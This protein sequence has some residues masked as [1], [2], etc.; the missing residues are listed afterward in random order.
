MTN[1]ADPT[2]VHSLRAWWG[3]ISYLLSRL[4]C[5]GG[6]AILI[7]WPSAATAD[8]RLPNV[9]SS[10]MVVQRDAPIQI[11]GWAEPREKVT[12]TFDEATVETVSDT[13]GYWS[14]TFE[15]LRA[16]GR[17]HN[18]K[19]RGN[20]DIELHDILVGDVW[21]GSGQSNMEMPMAETGDT[22]A[23]A[24]AS[25]PQIRLF[26]VTHAQ[27]Q[28]PA[29]DVDATWQRCTPDTVK[30]FSALLYHFG[31]RI[32][33][34]LDVPVGLIN[35]SWGGSPVEQWMPSDDQSGQMYNG[36]IAP[37]HRFTL[38][39]ILWYQGEANVNRNEG[40][41]YFH[42]MEALIGGW[43]KAWG[44]ELP[45][46]Y[47]QIAPWDYSGYL[48]D[49][50]P[51]L[52]EAQAACLS[53]ADTGMVVTTDLVDREGLLDG[54]PRNKRDVGDRLALW[55]LAKT[56]HCPEIVYSGPLYKSC[57][58]EGDRVRLHFL[59]AKGLRSSDGQPLREF[60]I[61]GDHDHFALATARIEGETV[62]VSSELVPH[63][64]QVRFGWRNLT[65]PNLV[66]GAGLP[67]SPFRT[68]ATTAQP[69]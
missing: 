13:S 37:L 39:G 23:I 53:I 7:S 48:P 65:S 25:R 43:R 57:E 36:M 18:L 32:H 68:K 14:T 19:I 10:H 12:V 49:K 41:Q 24:S 8:V 45:F 2:E 63:P 66:N 59:H 40:M 50:V 55:A 56:Y 60:E 51:V 44:D 58:T 61:A 31:R 28:T 9:I 15:A 6:A 3:A 1:L 22:T 30:T 5:A 34:E 26:H 21:L 16:D 46:Y 11:W 52:R 17:A 35:A 62:V 47:V 20:N 69:H 27:N 67:A 29:L 42:Q 33:K 38:R 64:T 54:H 4:L